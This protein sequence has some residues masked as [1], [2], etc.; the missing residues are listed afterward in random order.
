MSGRSSLT[1]RLG[2]AA[3]ASLFV[4]GSVTP[5]VAQAGWPKVIDVEVCWNFV[6]N[7]TMAQWTL[8]ADGT[9]SDQYG[10]T[11]E[12]FMA[13]Q[14]PFWPYADE[15]YVF[16]DNG[17]TTYYGN[18]PEPVSI[19]EFINEP[20]GQ[21]WV[22][23]YN[24]SNKTVQ[25]RNWT[26]TVGTSNVVLGNIDIPAKTQIILTSSPT[27]FIA[28]WGVGTTGVD[29]FQAGLPAMSNTGGSLTLIDGLGKLVW[30]VAYGDDDDVG[31]STV[32]TELNMHHVTH[33]LID[34]D[35]ID[36]ADGYPGYESYAV[37]NDR[38]DFSSTLGDRGSPLAGA[39]GTARP[40]YSGGMVTYHFYPPY[41]FEG[42]WCEGGC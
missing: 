35:G 17:E 21:E 40:L 19:N 3:L 6:C 37:H 1:G 15:F 30:Q 24:Y 22:E 13:S 25:M 23:L 42:N 34:R 12:Y 10:S 36:D 11:G 8:L 2:H 38:H 26:L 18:S 41:V 28:Q 16:Y 39:R 20:F 4:L 27:N 32:L 29:V 33:P 9:L 14:F 5:S 31:F 7:G